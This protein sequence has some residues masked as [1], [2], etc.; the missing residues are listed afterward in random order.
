L[1][2]GAQHQDDFS[3]VMVILCDYKLRKFQR[4]MLAA[5]EVVVA[6]MSQIDDTAEPRTPATEFSRPESKPEMTMGQ[7]V[8]GQVGQQV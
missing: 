1:T 5:D 2:G 3:S 6:K 7:R 8:T 4:R